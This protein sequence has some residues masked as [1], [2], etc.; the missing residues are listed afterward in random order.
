MHEAQTPTAGCLALQLTDLNHIIA[1]AS[2]NTYWNVGEELA[3]IT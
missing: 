2:L 1:T 3:R